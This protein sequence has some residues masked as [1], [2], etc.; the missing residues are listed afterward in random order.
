MKSEE[1]NKNSKFDLRGNLSSILGWFCWDVEYVKMKRK[2]PI[3]RQMFSPSRHASI[4]SLKARHSAHAYQASSKTSNLCAQVSKMSYMSHH[5]FCL[6]MRRFAQDKSHDAFSKFDTCNFTW[7][8]FFKP[9]NKPS[10]SNFGRA[11]T[12]RL[13]WAKNLGVTILGPS[14]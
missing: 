7:W 4:T 5:S 3:Y 9:R 13:S 14:I 6:S 8:R 1:S 12:V 2:F 10:S 11:F